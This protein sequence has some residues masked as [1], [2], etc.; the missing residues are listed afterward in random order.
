MWS[1]GQRSCCNPL[2]INPPHS[3][4]NIVN[5]AKVMVLNT[6]MMN[7][8]DLITSFDYAQCSISYIKCDI[9]NHSSLTEVTPEASQDHRSWLPRHRTG[10]ARSEGFYRISRKDKLKYLI[11]AKSN[12]E[13][14][15]E[16]AQ[17]FKKCRFDDIVCDIVPDFIIKLVL[18]LEMSFC[19][20]CAFQPTSK[21]PWELGL[22]SGLNSAACCRL[23]AVT[24]TWSSSTS[25]R[26]VRFQAK[27]LLMFQKPAWVP[28]WAPGSGSAVWCNL[29]FSR[30]VWTNQENHALKIETKTIKLVLIA[31]WSCASKQ[32]VYFTLQISLSVQK[33]ED[34]FQ[35]ESHPWVGP[36]CHGAN[37]SWW[38]GDR[39]C[40][41][42][43]QTGKMDSHLWK[44]LKHVHLF[45]KSLMSSW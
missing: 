34:L 4:F 2:H 38:N 42:N 27:L 28:A 32:H 21:L 18:N 36:V 37:R 25:W 7:S 11:N 20:E 1:S 43:Y 6:C 44:N 15:S 30:K 40:G 33:E 9:L 8:D 3:H 26:W 22:T 31:V 19:R 17:V 45:K 35:P 13:L 23:S 29:C 24:V 12:T 39:V 5:S 41:T 16:S 10:S 14:P